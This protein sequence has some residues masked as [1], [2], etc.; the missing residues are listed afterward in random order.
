MGTVSDKRR[1]EI[2][3]MLREAVDS[4]AD[5]VG[6]G[7]LGFDYAV[8]EYV[9]R[10]DNELSRAFKEYVEALRAFRQAPPEE[11]EERPSSEE[12][13]RAALQKIADRFQVPE[14]T[15]FVEAC[16]E[17]QDKRLSIGDTLYRQARQLRQ[18]R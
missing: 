14:V 12:V 5:A 16:L 1:A 11:G 4:F 17:S 10:T 3:Q 18:S 8:A 9:E 6:S 13:R 7:R 15:A 2:A